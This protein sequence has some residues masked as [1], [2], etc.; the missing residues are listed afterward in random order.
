MYL[1]AGVVCAAVLVVGL[2]KVINYVADWSTARRN[3]R[4]LREVYYREQEEQPVAPIEQTP[5]P[6]AATEQEAV[7]VRATK[8]PSMLPVVHYPNNHTAAVQQ[9]FRALHYQNKDI[10]AWLKIGTQLDEPVV[11]RDNTYYL[12]RDYL[13]N[14]NSNGTLFLDQEIQLN[15]RPYT[16]V[17]YGHN[18]KSGAMFGRLRSYEKQAFYQSH[19][20]ITFDTAYEDGR[21][22]VFAVGTYGLNGQAE[23][24][25]NLG[26]FY[27][28]LTSS[29]EKEIQRLLDGAVLT[30]PVDVQPDDQLLLL[31]TCV[32]DE[33]ERR[34]LAARRVREN[35]TEA[36]LIA[37]IREKF[38]N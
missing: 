28:R 29:R 27:S 7:Q 32:D 33:N 14:S 4:L 10:C 20:I 18:M 21:Y 1:A 30:S 13:G 6:Q 5:V 35:E 12:R 25:L 16:L 11:Q 26:A 36:A 37:A 9:R 8:R 22:V 34:I 19:A 31:V 15:T 2:C 38:A 23:N 17:V 24:Y 3:A